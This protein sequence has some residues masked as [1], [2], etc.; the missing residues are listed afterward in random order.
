L[1]FF[2]ASA[3]VFYGKAEEE[4]GFVGSRLGRERH[5][6]GCIYGSVV[7]ATV[8]ARNTMQ[9]RSLARRLLLGE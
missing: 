1:C 3:V 4:E 5:A 6:E 9:Y 8:E 2:L 7:E